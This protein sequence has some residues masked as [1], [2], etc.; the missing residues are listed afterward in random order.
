MV[1]FHNIDLAVM[2]LEGLLKVAEFVMPNVCCSSD[3][4]QGCD[5]PN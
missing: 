4:L 3:S 1:A 5:N 2:F